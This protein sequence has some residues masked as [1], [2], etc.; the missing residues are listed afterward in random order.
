M[1]DDLQSVIGELKGI[2]KRLS[3][4]YSEMW[5]QAK[6]YSAAERDYKIALQQ[7]ILELKTE[8]YA[9]TLILELAKG[10][11]HIAELRFQRDL[12]ERK[13]EVSKESIRSLRAMASVYQSILKVQDEV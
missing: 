8:G 5:K 12:A 11:E 4:C 13:Y 3:D 7:R 9:I 6:V 10:T 2:N 1:N